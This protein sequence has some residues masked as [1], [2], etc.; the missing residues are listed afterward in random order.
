MAKTYGAEV[1]G[2]DL[3][4]NMVGI[5]W[6]RS[7][8]YKDLRVRFE[9][10]DVTKHEYPEE[11][12]DLIYSRDTILHI[13]DKKALFDRFQK[14]LKPGGKIFITD[15]CCGPKPWS[16]DYAA[17]VEQRGYALLTPTEYGD[18]FRSLGY[19]NVVSEDKT[20]LFVFYLN[21]ELAEVAEIKEKFVNEF[22]VEDYNY[23][24]KG[25]NEKLVRCSQG[26]QRWGLFRA[27]KKNN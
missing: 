1:F 18:I 2:L 24:V 8:S 25:W 16:D 6:D 4:S 17:Y 23:I 3:S 12:F 9:I 7:P 11:Y 13:N 20:D 19:Q 21:K 14:W 26:H 27:E 15:Y 10:G 5:A 22:S